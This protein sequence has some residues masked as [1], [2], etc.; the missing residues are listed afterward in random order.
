MEL[1]QLGLFIATLFCSLVAGFVFAFAIVV[2]PGIKS[3][4]DHDFLQAFMVMDR[5]IQRNQPIFILVWLGSA[6]ILTISTGLGIW[7]LEGFD[8]VLLI[9]ACA[10]YLLGVQLPTVSINIPLNNRL[11][12]HDLES[13][14]AS[15]LEDARRS[16]E[17][18]WIRWN[19]IRTI[20][21]TATT[22]LLIF[23]LIRL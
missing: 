6:V 19:M 2:M 10:I 14:T 8:L 21:A 11:Q 12:S 22:A 9:V 4:G 5:V 13:M 20:L 23:L 17:S 3:L 18:R 16:F 1:I 7:Q 15:A